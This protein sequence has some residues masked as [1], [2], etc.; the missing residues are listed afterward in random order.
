M[1]GRDV[2][3]LLLLLAMI[4]TCLFGCWAVYGVKQACELRGGHIVGSG[5]KQ[6]WEC[7]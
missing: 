5:Y 2:K 1:E 3:T 6:G 4:L 7:R